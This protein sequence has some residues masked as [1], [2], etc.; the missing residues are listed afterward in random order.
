MWQLING[1]N[2]KTQEDGY[3]MELT[4]GNNIISNPTE[5]TEKLN[6]YF[7]NTVTELVQQN[8]NKGNYNNSRQEIK[9][10]PNSI[11]ISPVN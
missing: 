5:I 9:H 3:K 6:M 4:I 10:C 8:I 11:F 2:Y 1:E 7:T